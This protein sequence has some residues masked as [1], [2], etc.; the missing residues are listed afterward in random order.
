MDGKLY[1]K[2]IIRS[3]GETLAFDGEELYLAQDNTLLTRPDPNTTA[4]SYTGADG[5]EMIRQQASLYDQ[6][7]NGLIIPKT[8]GYWEL[9]SR[10]SLFFKLN[11]TY[12]IIYVKKDGTMF[13]TSNAWISAGL[14]I[15]PVPHEEY[16]GWTITFTIGNVAWTDYAEDASGKEIYSNTVTLPLIGANAGGEI[17][18]SVGLVADNVGEE[19]EAGAGGVQTVNIAS[20]ATIYPVW[21]VKGPCIN[22]VLQNNTTDTVAE[23]D[24]TV[25]EGQTLTVDFTAGTAYL[26]TALVT[27]YVNGIVSFAPGDNMAGFNSDGGTTETSTISWNNIIN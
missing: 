14:Q 1:I 15:V 7:I 9:T 27:R 3:D 20:T 24:G 2:K 6:T 13:A 5:G 8:T 17:W 26:D 16:S 23:Y 19:W 18:D 21:V 11:F 25:A 22:P 4:V 10:L 12:K